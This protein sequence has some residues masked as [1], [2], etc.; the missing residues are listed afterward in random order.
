MLLGS[1]ITGVTDKQIAANT[2][3]DTDKQVEM[4]IQGFFCYYLY[5]HMGEHLFERSLW[6]FLTISCCNAYMLL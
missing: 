2:N 5:I 4:H 1:K 3:K 6:F